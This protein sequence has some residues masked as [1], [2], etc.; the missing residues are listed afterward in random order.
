MKQAFSTNHVCYVKEAITFLFVQLVSSFLPPSLLSC[1]VPF[2]CSCW[3]PEMPTLQRRCLRQSSITFATPPME[4]T[5]GELYTPSVSRQGLEING[6][7]TV[8]FIHIKFATLPWVCLH[9]HVVKRK[10]IPTCYKVVI[11]N[12]GLSNLSRTCKYPLKYLTQRVFGWFSAS[13]NSLFWFFVL[14]WFILLQTFLLPLFTQVSEC[15]V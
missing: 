14:A 2:P 11:P 15:W 4:V 1:T 13:P 8:L 5:S 6:M 9:V 3:M 10:W 12:S 7:Y